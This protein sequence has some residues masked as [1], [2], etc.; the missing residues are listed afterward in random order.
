[1]KHEKNPSLWRWICVRIL[2][3]AIGSVITIAF[4]MWLRFSVENMWILYQMPQS[5]KEAFLPLLE[6]PETNPALFHQ[7]MDERWGIGYSA[8]SIMSADWIMVGVLVLVTIPFI[9]VLGLRSARPLSA[10]FITLATAAKAVA[11][12]E[13]TVRAGMVENVPAELV[14]FTEDFNTMTRQLE[15]YE[16]ELHASHVAMAHELR[17]PLTAAIGRVQGMLDG[18]FKPEPPQLEMV[19]KQLRL[20]S[21]LTDDLHLLSLAEA[22]QLTLNNSILSLT[23]VLKDRAAWLKPQAEMCGMIISINAQIPALYQGD[24]FRLGQVFT[25]LMENALRYAAEGGN[26]VITITPCVDGYH[27]AFRDNGPGVSAEFLPTMFDR[28]TRAE[29]SRARHSGGSGLGLSIAKAICVAHGGDIAGT[30]PA[31]G[32]LLLTVHLPVH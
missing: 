4:C 20:L 23:D 22:G 3:L 19:M 31:D 10:Q 26:L 15:R 6:N 5:L 2:T 14:Q 1:M 9:V 24:L 28:F 25:I 13:F 11:R 29:S 27:L 7:V 32:G 21:R 12:G 30:L 18:V 17:S 16:R 8:P